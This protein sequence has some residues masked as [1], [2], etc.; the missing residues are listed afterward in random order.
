MAVH[1]D[2]RF[3]L[4]STS[5]V[6]GDPLVHP[7]P[8]SY[9]GNVNPVG[10]RGVCD[11]AKRFGEALTTA[12]GSTYGLDAAIV[13]IFNTYG[14]RMR[15]DDGRAIP[16]FISQALR[17]DALTVYGKGLQTRSVCYVDDL[18]DGLTALLMSGHPGPMNI[19]NPQ[20]ISMLDL[21]NR[22]IE[23]T[24]SSSKVTFEPR[25]M[26]DPQIRQPDTSLAFRELG[27]RPNH[28]MIDGLSRTIAYFMDITRETDIPMNDMKRST[29]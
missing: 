2:A 1:K 29:A 9:W 17:G 4:A 10:P 27:W 26:D 23:L 7:Q 25:P 14:P 20:E 28:S 19:G 3:L 21:A 22:I 6:Y 11:E 13:R 5:E 8:E 18:V 15:L 12:Y 24:N 16:N